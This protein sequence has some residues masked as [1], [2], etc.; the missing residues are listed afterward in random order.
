MQQRIESEA[1]APPPGTDGAKVALVQSRIR[2]MIL[3]GELVPGHPI[4]E[5]ALAEQLNV[6]RT[7]MREALKLLA[8]EYLVDLSPYRGATVARIGRAEVLEVVQVLAALEALAAEL[9]CANM[10]EAEIGE[11][12]ALHYELQAHRARRD[13]LAYF[14]ANQRFHFA[15]IA[16]S[17]NAVLGEQHRILNARVYRLRFLAH[18]AEKRWDTAV[19]EH[20]EILA[21]FEARDGTAAARLLRDH[22]FGIWTRLSDLMAEDGSIEV[23]EG[24]E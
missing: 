4:R 16:G 6:S 3:K 9:G 8:A 13:R 15:I 10:T 11:L 1:E 19:Q 2:E 5:R 18:R 14:A 17:R 20:E 22:V 21:A 23:P 24:E 7:P 12:R